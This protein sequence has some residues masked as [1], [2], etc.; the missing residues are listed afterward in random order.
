MF[1]QGV[2]HIRQSGARV[3]G[4]AY[5]TWLSGSLDTYHFEGRVRGREIDA[6]HYTGHRFT[7]TLASSGLME[8]V[9]RHRNG[10][11]FRL[12]ARRVD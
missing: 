9:I 12:K 1:A 2:F 7:G 11:R 8:G 6:W 3:W 4:V 10:D 5:V